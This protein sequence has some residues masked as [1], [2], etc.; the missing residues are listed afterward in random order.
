MFFITE[1][2]KQTVLDFSKG[3][4]KYYDFVLFQYNINIK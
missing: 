3:F 2:V 1:K 4:L